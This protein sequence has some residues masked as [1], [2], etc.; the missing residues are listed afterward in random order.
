MNPLT[1]DQTGLSYQGVANG[2]HVWHTGSGDGLGLYHFA[3]APDLAVDVDDLAAVRTFYRA[4][5]NAGGVGIV[6]VQTGRVDGCPII[7]TVLKA[8]QPTGMVY[9]GSL[10]L[11]FRDCSYV[12]K[13]QCAEHGTTGVR[14]AVVLDAL[15]HSGDL[16]AAPGPDG[17]IPGWEQDPYDPRAISRVM[18]NRSEDERYDARFATHPLS[19]ARALLQRIQ[20]TLRIADAVR[21]LPPFI[22]PPP[23]PKPRPRWRPG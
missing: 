12:I 7:R 2:V 11:P 9:V 18:R 21:S 13:A 10:T 22:Y 6:E 17:R 3:K 4:S 8:P 1:F 23:R 15:M 16:A 5:A 20:T 14:E 19:R